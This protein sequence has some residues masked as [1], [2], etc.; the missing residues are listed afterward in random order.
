MVENP[1]VVV[2]VLAADDHSDDRTLYLGDDETC[3][4]FEVLT[5]PIE[6]GE[7]VIHV[8]DLRSKYRSVYNAAKETTTG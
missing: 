3:R 8:M 6:D 7:L 1:L 2:Q 5:V 4:A